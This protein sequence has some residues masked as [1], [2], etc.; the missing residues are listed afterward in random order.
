MTKTDATEP[1]R[2]VGAKRAR[3]GEGRTRHAD[4]NVEGALPRRSCDHGVCAE[5]P[6]H[7]LAGDDSSSGKDDVLKRTP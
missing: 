6:E 3:C 2:V 1:S 7:T 5:R 4:G